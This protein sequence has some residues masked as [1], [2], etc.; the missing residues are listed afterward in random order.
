MNSKLY[1]SKKKG[2][3]YSCDAF[4]IKFLSKKLSDG[5]INICD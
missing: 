4:S 3:T 5:A 1:A 2:I